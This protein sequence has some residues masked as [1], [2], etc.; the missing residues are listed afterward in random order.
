MAYI[1]NLPPFE[2][3]TQSFGSWIELFDEYCTLNKVPGESEGGTKKAFFLTHIGARQYNFLHNACLPC[4]KNDSIR[5]KLLSLSNPNYSQ[6]KEVVLQEEASKKQL[7]CIKGSEPNIGKVIYSQAQGG[8]N[9]QTKQS[10]SHANTKSH[11]H[12]NYRSINPSQRHYEVQS[13]VEQLVD[14]SLNVNTLEVNRLEHKSKL[15][16]LVV[17]N[18]ELTM[19][20]DTGAAISIISFPCYVKYFNKLTIF[21]SSIKL[22][23]ISGKIEIAGIIKYTTVSNNIHGQVSVHHV[24]NLLRQFCEIEEHI[25]NRTLTNLELKCEVYYENTHQRVENGRCVAVACLSYQARQILENH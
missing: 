7:Q 18:V 20:V 17:E 3:G 5:K 21:P 4:I 12:N 15:L 14:E 6:V 1:G 9:S 16:K 22:N 24:D 25:E 10:Y 13:R 2:E 8:T 19:E 23:G 11:H